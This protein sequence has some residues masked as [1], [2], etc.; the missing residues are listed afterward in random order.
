MRNLEKKTLFLIIRMA[1]KGLLSIS[2]SYKKMGSISVTL[3]SVPL[4]VFVFISLLTTNSL[5]SK[6][7]ILIIQSS[8]SFI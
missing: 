6:Y 3:V 7:I 5:S 4:S 2:L 1:Y 8:L